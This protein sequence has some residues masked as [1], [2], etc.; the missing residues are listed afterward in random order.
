MTRAII[1]YLTRM[2]FEATIVNGLSQSLMQIS[3]D[4]QSD[5]ESL[6]CSLLGCGGSSA[7]RATLIT[8]NHFPYMANGM[9]VVS[10]LEMAQNIG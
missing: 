4:S 6:I 8:I 7:E 10:E 1:K 3:L 2:I 5:S 9:R